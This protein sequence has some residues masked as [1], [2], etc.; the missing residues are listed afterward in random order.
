MLL[1]TA[2][3]IRELGLPV[4][5]VA[6]TGPDAVL[7]TASDAGFV[8]AGLVA[9]GRRQWMSALRAWDR[10]RTGLLWCHGL[11]PAVATAHHRYRL[12]HLHQMPQNPAQRSLVPLARRRALATVVPS[13]WMQTQIRHAEVMENWTDDIAL[14][15]PSPADVITIGYLGR[16]STAK[17]VD[18]LAAAVA[19]LERERPGRV[20]LLLAGDA[21]FVSESERRVV[22][23]AL[24]PIA[25]LVQ[26]PGWMARKDFFDRVDVVVVPSVSPEAF[27]L[28]AAETM[29]AGRPLVVT[30]TGALP[31]VVGEPTGLIVP[32]ADPAALADTLRRLIDGVVPDGVVLRRQRWSRRYSPAAGKARVAALLGQIMDTPGH[33]PG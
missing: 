4:G 21:R 8:T 13:T 30:R 24:A 19:E 15:T 31:E 7:A 11:V 32:P 28:S 16:L 9:R 10:S 23:S 6:P 2:E 33:T 14:T 22:E 17:G 3:A 12:V 1:R 5:V 29:A 20:R 18:V 26:R 27:G 25:D